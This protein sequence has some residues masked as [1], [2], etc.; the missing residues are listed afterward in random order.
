MSQAAVTGSRSAT[1]SAGGLNDAI[2]MHVTKRIFLSYRQAGGGAWP[3][4]VRS[5]IRRQVPKNCS[6]KVFLDTETTLIGEDYR[7]RCLAEAARCDALIALVGPTWKGAL[8]RQNRIDEPDDLVR[9]ELV[10]A[11]ANGGLVIP[12]LVDGATW[13]SMKSLPKELQWMSTIRG[14]SIDPATPTT[15]IAELAKHVLSRLHL[16]PTDGDDLDGD[17][18]PPD[19]PSPPG[20]TSGPTI[21]VKNKTGTVNVSTY[22]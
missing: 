13:S 22:Q 15:S 2:G 19:S 4:L 20:G 11:R 7:E 10:A 1:V 9:Q 16:E 3:Y 18:S 8:G 17:P 5:E 21:K 6:L 14:L 12:V